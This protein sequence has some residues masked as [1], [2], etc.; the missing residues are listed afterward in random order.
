MTPEAIN[1][2]STVVVAGATLVLAALT[3]WY[4]RITSKMLAEMRASRD[5]CVLL[6]LEAPDVGELHLVI[7]NIG[8]SVARNVRFEV[9]HDV[10]WLQPVGG[11]G[12]GLASW[13]VIRNGVRY[14]TPGRSLRFSADRF[15][16]HK[17]GMFEGTLQVKVRYDN[18]AGRELSRDVTIDTKLFGE[19]RFDSYR[20]SNWAVAEALKALDRGMNRKDPLR[21][22]FL[23]LGKRPCPFCGELIP[24]AARKCARCHEFLPPPESHES[25]SGAPPGPPVL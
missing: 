24:Q 22:V 21:S 1:A 10:D 25:T 11:E 7:S 13:P 6:D 23:G 17:T 19:V 15:Q 18:E 14:L 5:P 2:V 4:A 20:D 12:P 8:Q 3:A 16:L 9:L